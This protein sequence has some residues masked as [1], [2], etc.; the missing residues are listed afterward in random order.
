MSEYKYKNKSHY[1]C[2]MNEGD[3]YRQRYLDSVCAF[4]STELEK[5]EKR[6]PTSALPKKWQRSARISE[7]NT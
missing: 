5:S 4:I 7:E 3:E 1:T 6:E 2:P